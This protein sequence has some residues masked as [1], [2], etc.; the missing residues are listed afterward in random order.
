LTAW[1]TEIQRLRTR[2]ATLNLGEQV[3]G[4]GTPDQRVATEAAQESIRAYRELFD[5]Y[6]R[7][8]TEA[9]P[10]LELAF[11]LTLAGDDNA[12]LYFERIK[13]DHPNAP[14]AAWA[15][16]GLA[17]YWFAKRGAGG[18]ALDKAVGAYTD[19]SKAN[20]RSV[21]DYALLK[22]AW[23]RML[24]KGAKGGDDVERLFEAAAG[25]K[26]RFVAEAA[27][28]DLA[29]YW[30]ERNNPEA[31]KAYFLKNKDRDLYGATLE[32]IGAKAQAAGRAADAVQAYQTLLTEAPTR[33]GNFVVYDKL[34]TL[35]AASG[36]KDRLAATLVAMKRDFLTP[37]PWRQRHEHDHLLAGRAQATTLKDLSRFGLMQY[38]DYQSSGN[39]ASLQASLVI[40]DAFVT[41]APVDGPATTVRFF[42]AEALAKAQRHEPAAE[43]Y[44]Q[45]AIAK[46]A[47]AAQRDQAA[48]RMLDQQL[49]AT[50]ADTAEA[51]AM[52]ATKAKL[53][54]LIDV[55]AKIS[56]TKPRAFEMRLLAA[57]IEVT[58]KRLAAAESRLKLLVAEAP[59][60]GVGIKAAHL[61]IGVYTQGTRWDDL[62]A[63]ARALLAAGP[64]ARDAALT[65]ELRLGL[66][67]GMWE[68]GQALAQT[69]GK[70]LP[71]AEAFLDFQR[72]FPKDRDADKAV[73]LAYEI[74]QRLGKGAGALKAADLL[75]GAYAASR[76]HADVEYQVAAVHAQLLDFDG[77]AQALKRFAEDHAG[78]R[79]VAA[80]FAEAAQAFRRAQN[81]DS[82]ALMLQRLLAKFPNATEARGAWLEL[83]RAREGLGDA[84][85]AIE[86]YNRVARAATASEDDRLFAKAKAAVL[87]A[88][89]STRALFEL[90]SGELARALTA[91]P[92]GQG[93]QA[94]H[95]LAE[96]VFD[97]HQ[98]GM[99]KL[100]E[101]QP[102]KGTAARFVEGDRKV[103][104]LLRDAESAVQ[105][106]VKLGDPEFSVAADA[107]L[108]ESCDKVARAY[109]A[110]DNSDLIDSERQQV[111]SLRERAILS[112]Q[113]LIDR[114]LAEAAPLAKALGRANRWRE[115]A[116]HEVRAFHPGTSINGDE[117]ILQPTYL[118][119]RVSS[120]PAKAAAQ[121]Q[122]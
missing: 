91:L 111:E 102:T 39:A 66:R 18:T 72:E 3:Q 53:I 62:I 27:R 6:P 112:M 43:Q 71:A 2:L 107:T 50:A 104:A 7:F 14:E 78:D 74:Y 67:T 92:A 73:Y 55:Y 117:T 84:K 120:A 49:A 75:I 68:R 8:A 59:A 95:V 108:V 51:S 42:Y 21:H 30:A 80:A 90:A 82:S 63:A 79:R 121:D 22:L 122:H 81:L 9:K 119:L 113:G 97:A 106:I 37:S 24:A 40:L 56:A 29:Y 41:V 94:R 88:A 38:Q 54:E 100:A 25:S 35:L 61:L 26:T 28:D 86:A 87:G 23:I 118:S 58:Y 1:S 36:A 99:E 76:H 93:A 114:R 20:V 33:A 69:A 116:D 70:E 110:L 13:K 85:R 64:V 103:Q 101:L 32:R 105:G 57:Q 77:E 46:A 31:A 109:R 44:R 47:T 5:H 115:L 4:E 83:A 96:A 89:G 34:A 11:M 10:Q 52:P 98:S 45:V 65:G 16:L 19:G 17:E 12:R 48:E 15:S 60:N